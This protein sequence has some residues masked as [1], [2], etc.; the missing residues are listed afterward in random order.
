MGLLDRGFGSA[1]VLTN[2]LTSLVCDVTSGDNPKDF[3][4]LLTDVNPADERHPSEPVLSTPVWRL[5]PQGNPWP[6]GNLQL[7]VGEIV[8]GYASSESTVGW[9]TF[10]GRSKMRPPLLNTLFKLQRKEQ[11]SEPD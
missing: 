4:T 8:P 10:P 1:P 3:A 7:S 9:V 6:F 5:D 2:N 11:R